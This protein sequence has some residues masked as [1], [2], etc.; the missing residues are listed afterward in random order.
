ME[1]HKNEQERIL[2][3]EEAVMQYDTAGVLV[4]QGKFEEAL[5]CYLFA[6]DHSTLVS[7]WGG[8]RLSFLPAEIARLG[9]QYK[10]AI[11]ALQQRR[12]EREKLILE[13][14]TDFSLLAE[15]TC[16]NRYLEDSKREVTIMAKLQ[17]EGKLSEDLKRAIIRNN[18]AHYFNESKSEEILD[19][20]RR[21][22]RFLMFTI[23]DFE[24]SLLFPTNSTLEKQSVIKQGEEVY[25]LLIAS[26]QE[27][28]AD[29]L[30]IRLLKLIPE[31]EMFLGLML[32]SLR[33]GSS[34]RLSRLFD[35]ARKN[36]A[37]EIISWLE[38][39]V[40]EHTPEKH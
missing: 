6:F 11:E 36:F 19:E 38:T 23:V 16:L 29:E 15:W 3:A 35:I 31:K 10:P 37:K 13:G 18:F 33:T 4:R 28:R 39:K 7:G 30:E 12:D 5:A 32:A 24:M 34:A 22:G 14:E 17:E 1:A 26:L 27:Q 9:K 20:I 25:E 2:L 21:K 8:V 40:S